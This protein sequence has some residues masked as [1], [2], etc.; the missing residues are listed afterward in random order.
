MD[1]AY[2]LSIIVSTRKILNQIIIESV[3]FVY[4]VAIAKINKK[5]TLKFLFFNF[6][7]Q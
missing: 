5:K 1:I 7:I 2:L 3:Y 4:K 6:S